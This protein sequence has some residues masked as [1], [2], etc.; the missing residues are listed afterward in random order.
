ME[1]RILER[2]RADLEKMV[3]FEGKYAY[4]QN[5]PDLF[6]DM[7]SSIQHF[8]KWEMRVMEKKGTPGVYQVIFERDTDFAAI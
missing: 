6:V 8:P 2:N 4:I 3:A 7:E 1:R 5:D